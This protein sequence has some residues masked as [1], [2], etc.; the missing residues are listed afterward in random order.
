ML[1]DDVTVKARTLIDAQNAGDTADH[2]ADHATHDGANRAGGPF[3]LPR[4]SLNSPRN[5]LGLRDGR[6]RHQGEKGGHP[7]KTA[8]H[9][10]SNA[11]V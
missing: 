8:D 1:L 4:A 10:N 5:A 9:G 11:V 2:A 3:A 7:D 6:K